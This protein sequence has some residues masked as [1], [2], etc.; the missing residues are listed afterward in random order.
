MGDLTKSW[1]RD[2]CIMKQRAKGT[3]DLIIE[4]SL[5]PVWIEAIQEPNT[6]KPSTTPTGDSGPPEA[7]AVPLGIT[8]P[9]VSLIAML[10]ALTLGTLMHTTTGLPLTSEESPLSQ[11]QGRSENNNMVLGIMTRFGIEMN[12]TNCWVCQHMPQAANEP[13]IEVVP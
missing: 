9:S 13:L 1:E 6:T 5:H 4:H 7:P 12:Y 11:K 10:L 2:N 3:V 8:S